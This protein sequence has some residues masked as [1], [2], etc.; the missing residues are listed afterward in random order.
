V[1]T[2]ELNDA[3]AIAAE[4]VAKLASIETRLTMQARLQREAV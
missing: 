4:L 2:R 3:R 1:A